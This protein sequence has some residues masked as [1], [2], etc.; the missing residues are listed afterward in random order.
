[1]ELLE[2]SQKKIQLRALQ[3]ERRRFELEMGNFDK[4]KRC[5]SVDMRKAQT[6]MKRRLKR[7]KERQKEISVTRGEPEIYGQFITRP[8]T[9][10]SRMTSRPTTSSSYIKR[11]GEFLDA[12]DCDRQLDP[13]FLTDRTKSKIDLRPSSAWTFRNQPRPDTQNLEYRRLGISLRTQNL[14][15]PA[16]QIRYYDDE[17]LHERNLIYRQILQQRKQREKEQFNKIAMKVADFC[18]V[19]KKSINKSFKC[20]LRLDCVIAAKKTISV[21]KVDL[22]RQTK[23]FISNKAV[24]FNIS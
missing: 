1:M 11:M 9:A 5:I 2:N 19:G 4:A 14:G 15:T 6:E 8:K 17:E 21:R 23:P 3:V 16:S 10:S 18:D 20:C 22:P 24:S 7:Y 12:D 13:T